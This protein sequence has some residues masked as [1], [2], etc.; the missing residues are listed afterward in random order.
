MNTMFEPFREITWRHPILVLFLLILHLGGALLLPTTPRIETKSPYPSLSP[1][2]TRFPLPR[3]R[4][5]PPRVPRGYSLVVRTPLQLHPSTRPVLVP[6]GRMWR[7]NHE[8]LITID[9]R[10]AKTVLIATEAV[11]PCYIVARTERGGVIVSLA[12]DPYPP[13]RSGM[14]KLTKRAVYRYLTIAGAITLTFGCAS[15]ADTVGFPSPHT[16]HGRIYDG[17][18]RAVEGVE[19]RVNGW[20]RTKGDSHGRFILTLCAQTTHAPFRPSALRT[21]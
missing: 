7:A 11:G 1:N 2:P 10:T 21:D 20:R 19:V 14:M 16:V 5:F 9:R 4:Y 15:T 6:T 12:R 8:Y 13:R 18:N 3:W 17:R